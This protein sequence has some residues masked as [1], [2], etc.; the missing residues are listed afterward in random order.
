MKRPELA[1]FLP[2]LVGGGA[3]RMM[4]NLASGMVDR[5]VVPDLVVASEEGPYRALVPA[6]CR[7]VNL[8]ARRVLAALPGLVRYLRNRRP[9]ALLAAMDHANLVA[10]AAGAWARVPTRVYVSVRSNLTQEALHSPF[11]RGRALPLL[12]RHGYPRA[13]AVIAVSQG[14]ADDLQ[15]LLGVRRAR[16]QVI[17][18]PVVT[19]ELT[20][21]ARER[22]THPWF[23]PGGP[24]VILAAGRLVPQKDYPTLLEAFATLDP[25]V[26]RRLLILGE[27]P[28][29]Q[30]LEGLI[31]RLGLVGRVALPGFTANPFAF[32]A[33]CDLFVLSSAWEGLPGVLIQAMACGT[34]VVSTDCPSGPREIL[35]DGRLGRLVPVGDVGALGAAIARTLEEPRE[36]ARL[37]RRAADFAVESVT[38][39]YLEVLGLRCPCTVS[40]G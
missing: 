4:L 34:P 39:Q 27:G 13:A 2:S 19:P 11:L 3:E 1:I 24:Q 21:L 6:P 20:R 12:A 10:L 38:R 29:R 33:H 14:V 16:I 30:M 26:E 37:Q 15:S 35:A 18:N 25:G 17:P 36:G 8:R 32:M 9:H 28:E 23:R 31:A 22:P 5:G 40:P 7:L